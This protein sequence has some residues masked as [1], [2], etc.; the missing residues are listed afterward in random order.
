MPFEIY[1]SAQKTTDHVLDVYM[2]LGYQGIYSSYLGIVP[3]YGVGFAILAAGTEE[4]PDLNAYADIIATNLLPAIVNT[5]A[6]QA[7]ENFSGTFKS[8]NS[9][10]VVEVDSDPGMSV[11]KLT[12][13][14][15]NARAAY[16][17]ILG[18]EED[19]LSI[20][21]FPTNLKTEPKEGRPG[22]FVFWAVFQDKNELEDAGT[23]TCISWMSV[24]S[25]TY[26]GKALDEFV[27]LVDEDGSTMGI[28]V[29]A[30]QLK[31]DRAE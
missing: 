7:A 30:L 21:L 26:G 1:N 13:N 27:F 29:P 16:A 22:R 14:G 8:R 9:S 12:S 2:K 5:A 17:K 25:P 24:D 19:A 18:F 15:A 28:E 20:R 6:S 11:S 31:L 10:L 3:S 23:P 4:A